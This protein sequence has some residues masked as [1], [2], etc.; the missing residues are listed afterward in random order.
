MPKGIYKRTE[1]HKL[2]LKNRKYT[3]GDKISK[4]NK[5]KKLSKDHKS[6]IGVSNK[7]KKRTVEHKKKYS[8]NN[9]RFWKG[10]EF[11]KEHKDKISKALKGKRKKSRSEEEYLRNCIEYHNW[12]KEVFSKDNYTCQKCLE[13]GGELNAHH[14]ENFN[15]NSK[16]N[17]NIS[18]GITLCNKHH[19]EFHIKYGYKNNTLEQILEF[20]K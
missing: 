4:A 6:K 8:I 2:A 18:N 14:I 16:L 12:R 9:C 17:F 20:I 3:W 13:R 15:I 11:T 7:G 10:K 5:D 19:K 1:K